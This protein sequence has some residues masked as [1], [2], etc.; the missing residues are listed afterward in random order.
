ML[1][2][3]RAK[4]SVST[5]ATTTTFKNTTYESTIQI[6]AD[7]LWAGNFATGIPFTT[8]IMINATATST[9]GTTVTSPAGF[10]AI[11]SVRIIHVPAVTQANGQLA[12]TT[13]ST[14]ALL[15]QPWS[16][17]TT[18]LT[19]RSLAVFSGMND[20]MEKYF[21]GQ[22][23][24]T[25]VTYGSSDV[26]TTSRPATNT[27][28]YPSTTVVSFSTPYLHFAVRAATELVEHPYIQINPVMNPNETDSTSLGSTPPPPPSLI[29]TV[30]SPTS[31]S[32]PPLDTDNV[33]HGFL[34]SDIIPW[35]LKNP[36]YLTQYPGLASCLPGGPSIDFGLGCYEVAPETAG[37]VPDLTTGSAVTVEGVGCFHPGNCPAASTSAPAAAPAV[38]VDAAHVSNTASA[39]V[40]P[41]EKPSVAV[42]S[43]SNEVPSQPSVS[44]QPKHTESPLQPSVSPQIPPVIEAHSQASPLLQDIPTSVPQSK[45]ASQESNGAPAPNPSRTASSAQPNPISK[46]PST[47]IVPVIVISSTTF[48]LAPSASA[49][50]INGQ[51]SPNALQIPSPSSAPSPSVN[52]GAIIMSAFGA[53]PRSTKESAAAP[54]ASSPQSTFSPA[55][56]ILT[57]ANSQVVTANSASAFI[58]KSQTLAPGSSPIILSGTTYS[59]APE[60]SAIIV[61]GHTSSLLPPPSPTTT[62]QGATPKT[63]P[64]FFVISSQTLNPGSPAITLQGTTYSLAPAVSAIVV[65]GHTS[66]LLS[67]SSPLPPPP[68]A[69]ILTLANSPQPLTITANSASAFVVGGTQTLAPGSSA[70]VAQGTTYSLVPGGSAV[71]VNGAS[72]E[73]LNAASATGSASVSGGSVGGGGQEG[74]GNGSANSSSAGV[75]FTGSGKSLQVHGWVMLIAGVLGVLLEVVLQS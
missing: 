65:N 28:G 11:P 10:Y 24:P 8:E 39:N 73:T 23:L 43:K 33:A 6:G 62:P 60:A 29:S 13:S 3:K 45:P 7:N 40:V 56:A 47:P 46:S 20:G 4:Q 32:A 36:D 48:S 41:A 70:I 57:L 34:P 22:Q 44:A 72:T 5:D 74:S 38:V 26:Y 59:L 35:M 50:V 37:P 42:Q 71:V 49:L 51:T 2:G 31:T 54:E 68:A 53:P 9:Y 30:P 55:T 17:S 14:W 25:Q 58:I 27:S 15:C 18:H 64:Y 19:T 63:T 52:I 61:N 1:C 69:A 12:C 16:E 75:N 21:S 67:P 66:P